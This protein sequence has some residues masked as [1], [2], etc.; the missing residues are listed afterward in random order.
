MN[1]FRTV[2]SDDLTPPASPTSA[3]EPET[4]ASDSNSDPE[5]IP[6]PPT[7]TTANLDPWTF[8]LM[9][10]KLATK[11]ESVIE[12]YRRDLEELGSGLKKE[13]AAI[14]DVASRA[15]KDLPASLEASASAA[16][17]S[18]ETVG[19]AIDDIGATVWKSTAQ[20]ISHGRD[21]SNA[22]SP[23]YNDHD[24]DSS[25]NG[26]GG[27]GSSLPLKP[28]S[29]YDAQLLALQSNLNTYCG[30]PEDKEGY[31]GW[32]LGLRSSV[33][34]EKRDEIE[35][36]LTEN[37]VVREIYDEVMPSKVNIETFWSRYFYRAQKLKEAEEARAKI[38]KRVISVE[39]E[40]LSWDFDDDVENNDTAADID[41]QRKGS[42]SQL[43]DGGGTDVEQT[44]NFQKGGNED[45]SEGTKFGGGFGDDQY[46]DTKVEKA[47]GS[48]GGGGESCKDSDV[49]VVSSQQSFVPEVEDLGW[50]EIEDIGSNDEKAAGAGNAAA[51][52][53][54]DLRKRLGSAD[55]EEDLSW[56]I[57]D[58]DEESVKH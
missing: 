56:D 21:L 49:S 28:Y 54:V 58:E 20:I 43:N 55:E 31:D 40:D 8:G 34:E 45:V 19:Q 11:S 46:S 30:E 2:F 32:R 33:V 36:L 47:D 10:R 15:V 42:Q 38:V 48:N 41:D 16:Q 35:K 4:A 25:N 7:T 37:E 27:R 24:S 3:S 22:S 18:L 52:S 44:E 50:D 5:S 12:T 57:E 26:G 13:T 1:F 14:R 29:R 6:P 9:I 51:T 39:E 17:E 23:D 53:R